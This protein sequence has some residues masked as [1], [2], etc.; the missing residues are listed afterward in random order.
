MPPESLEAVR[1]KQLRSVWLSVSLCWFVLADS[2][3]GLATEFRSEKIPRNRLGTHSVIPRKKV[4][5]PRVFRVPRKSPFRSSKRNGT[6]FR[7]KI[8]FPEQTKV[9]ISGPMFKI[10]GCRVLLGGTLLPGGLFPAG[11]GFRLRNYP[12]HNYATLKCL[13]AIWNSDGNDKFN[14]TATISQNC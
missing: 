11:S 10:C 8:S 7:G 4:L 9:V 1:R 2:P 3:L 13:P 6:E 5:I 14:P 12:A